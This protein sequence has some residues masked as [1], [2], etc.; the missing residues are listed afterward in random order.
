MMIQKAVAAAQTLPDE[1]VLRLA[2]M[3]NNRRSGS[4]T[5]HVKEGEI[6]QWELRETA[7]LN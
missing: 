4:L 1:F 3:M 5:L 2:Q 7:R 6:M